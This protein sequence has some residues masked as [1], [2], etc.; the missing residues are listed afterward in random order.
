M[1]PLNK[2]VYISVE[3][4]LKAGNIVLTTDN[5]SYKVG[6]IIAKADDCEQNFKVGD[7][8]I[9][10]SRSLPPVYTHEDT[11]DFYFIEE[12]MLMSIEE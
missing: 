1:K 8:V 12:K 11:K 7:K 6:V 3:T 10:E 4:S 2:R 5:S 9:V